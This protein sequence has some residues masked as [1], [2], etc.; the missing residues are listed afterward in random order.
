M[1]YAITVFSNENPTIS[2]ITMKFSTS[3]HSCIQEIDA[4]HSTIERYLSRAEYYS[5]LSLMRLLIKVNLRKPYKILQ[6]RTANFLDFRTC[7]NN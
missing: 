2:S 4:V 3:E 6:T 5:P 1:S 7:S